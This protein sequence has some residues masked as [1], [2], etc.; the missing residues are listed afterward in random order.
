MQQMGAN[1]EQVRRSQCAEISKFKSEMCTSQRADGIRLE[2]EQRLVRLT[3]D[4]SSHATEIGRLQQCSER[5]ATSVASLK[6]DTMSERATLATRTQ[7]AR[8]ALED[9]RANTERSIA[10]L[11]T[12]HYE[13]RVARREAFEARESV[14]Q[15]EAQQFAVACSASNPAQI[16]M[17]VH[18][19]R[20]RLNGFGRDVAA[21]GDPIRVVDQ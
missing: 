20:D 5:A 13:D 4:H 7:S 17:E 2:L 8:A 12:E 3:T 18:A 6:S 14:R 9:L 11:K 15:L 10:A 16:V 19:L 1:I 21:V